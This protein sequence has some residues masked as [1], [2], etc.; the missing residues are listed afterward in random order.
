MT[1]RNIYRSY[2]T[3]LPT[4]DRSGPVFEGLIYIKGKLFH[5]V[6]ENGNHVEVAYAIKRIPNLKTIIHQLIST[7]PVREFD[8][9]V[10]HAGKQGSVV[11]LK[12]YT[13]DIKNLVDTTEGRKNVL[14]ITKK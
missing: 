4:R 7:P 12:K 10:M 14:Y 9:F 5:C 2:V 6:N 11:F 1:D 13:K 8:G 3:G